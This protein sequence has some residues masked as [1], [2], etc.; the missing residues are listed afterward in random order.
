M[1]RYLRVLLLSTLGA[2]VFL[3]NVVFAVLSFVSG[4]YGQGFVNFFVA[5][6]MLGAF[7]A[8]LEMK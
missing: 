7:W 5:V 3:A 8:S 4:D 1:K 2:L 6:F